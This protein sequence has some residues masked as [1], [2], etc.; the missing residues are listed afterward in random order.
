MAKKTP[1]KNIIVVFRKNKSCSNNLLSVDKLHFPSL[2]YTGK[3]RRI[4]KRADFQ[5]QELLSGH[6]RI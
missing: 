3:K 1:I 4:L 2:I 5:L 6:F